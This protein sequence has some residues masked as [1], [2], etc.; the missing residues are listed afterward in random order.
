M[1]TPCWRC[2]TLPHPIASGQV[3]LGDSAWPVAEVG[4]LLRTGWVV[5]VWVLQVQGESKTKN[6]RNPNRLRCHKPF[7]G[8]I[9]S[10]MAAVDGTSA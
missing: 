1:Q 7:Q 4:G 2:I 3:G 8:L 5:R 10:C 6:S 9:T